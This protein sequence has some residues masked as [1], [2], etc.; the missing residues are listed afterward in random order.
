MGLHMADPPRFSSKTTVITRA[1]RA[2][3]AACAPVA[4]ALPMSA[5]TGIVF[6]SIASLALIGLSLLCAGAVTR[7]RRR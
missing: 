3:I 2:A 6:Q 4:A 1:V 5:S 7:R